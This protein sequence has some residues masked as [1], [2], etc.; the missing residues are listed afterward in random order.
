MSH[1]TRAWRFVLSWDTLLAGGRTIPAMTEAQ[2]ARLAREVGR[3]F[4]RRMIEEYVP[5]IAQC[6]SMLSEVVIRVR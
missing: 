6:V 5:R 1:G 2:A 3:E 4:R